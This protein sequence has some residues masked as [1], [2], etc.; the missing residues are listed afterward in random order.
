MCFPYEIIL[1]TKTLAMPA[2]TQPAA[3]VKCL[4]PKT[5]GCLHIDAS[6]HQL[7]S[8]AIYSSLV[9]GKK[10]TYTQLVEGVNL[11]LSKQKVAFQGSVEW[12]AVAVK[13]DMEARGIIEAF[14]QRGKKLNALKKEEPL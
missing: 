5:G 2:T 4:N 13:N 9:G 6:I 3:K 14:T 7:F 11:Y 1:S 8:N 10:L 12:Y